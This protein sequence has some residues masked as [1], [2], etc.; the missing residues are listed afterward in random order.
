MM[1]GGVIQI[2]GTAGMVGSQFAV[3][4]F[5]VL[6]S[7]MEQ[8]SSRNDRV[9]LTL[10]TTWSSG[11]KQGNRARCDRWIDEYRKTV[12]SIYGNKPNITKQSQQPPSPIT[13]PH[14]IWCRRSNIYFVYM[15]V[16]RC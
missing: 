16:A 13:A 1:G 5:S 3:L 12:S 15:C 14:M 10:V 4:G 9:E 6:G 11:I 2:L 7:K 8:T